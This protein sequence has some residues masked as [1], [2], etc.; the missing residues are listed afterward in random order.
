MIY[1][2]LFV[3]FLLVIGEIGPLIIELAG[4]LICYIV[5]F[6]L[7]V[8]FTALKFASK[9]LLWV[10]I[11]VARGV[12]RVCVLAGCG[13]RFTALLLYFLIDEKLRGARDEQ[14][15]EEPDDEYGPSFDDEADEIAALSDLEAAYALFGLALTFTREELHHAYKTAIRKAH[16]DLGGSVEQA[17]ELN[18]ARDLIISAHG[19][20]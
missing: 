15:D 12:I 8:F 10:L 2:I 20:A 5:W 7:L 13:I 4:Y 6:F 19:W 16:P 18:V 1:G 11:R 14:S 9:G 3:F 17:Q